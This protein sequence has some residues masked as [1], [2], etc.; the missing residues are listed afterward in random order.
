MVRVRHEDGHEETH[1]LGKVILR[2]DR[3]PGVQ[4]APRKRSRSRSRSPRRAHSPDWTRHRG[5][6]QDEMVQELR[7]RQRERAVCSSGKDYARKPIGFMSGLAL[8]RDIGVASTR[9][10]EEE[11]YA[12]R[13]VEHRK[14][15]TEEDEMERRKEMREREFQDHEKR[16]LM[17]QLY[18]KY[19]SAQPLP[20]GQKD[21][22]TLLPGEEQPE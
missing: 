16:Q 6:S 15:M 1:H 12:P 7:A 18:E 9:L 19:G 21:Q 17:Q 8:K 22:P 4:P 5:K 10:R 3:R 2:D 20:K 13:Q 14:Q 11:T